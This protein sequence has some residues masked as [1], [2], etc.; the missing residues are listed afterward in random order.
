MI[1][2]HIQII[3][4]ETELIAEKILIIKLMRCAR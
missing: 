4:A 3:Q 1:K 2:A